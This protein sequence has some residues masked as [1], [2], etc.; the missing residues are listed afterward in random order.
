MKVPN[1]TLKCVRNVA[2]LK[3]CGVHDIQE[4]V[5]SRGRSR[6]SATCYLNRSRA[7]WPPD[8]KQ[9]YYR[10]EVS[11]RTLMQA[12][13]QTQPAFAPGKTTALPIQSFLHWFEAACACAVTRVRT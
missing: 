5:R 6:H 9:L 3:G 2:I 11:Q 4:R 7:T 1:E 12:D 10:G 8:G 13:I